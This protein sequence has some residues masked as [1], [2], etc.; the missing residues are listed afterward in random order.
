MDERNATKQRDFEEG[1]EVYL[2][3]PTFRCKNEKLGLWTKNEVNPLAPSVLHLAPSFSSLSFHLP[4]SQHENEGRSCT[5]LHLQPPSQTVGRNH[6]SKD[7]NAVNVYA[8]ELLQILQLE[9]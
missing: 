5:S 4:K 9:D 8:D 2:G 6:G 1:H 7:C 3:L